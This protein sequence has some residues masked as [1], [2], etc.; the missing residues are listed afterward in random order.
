MLKKFLGTRYGFAA[1]LIV[2]GALLN[3]IMGAAFGAISGNFLKTSFYLFFI[4]IAPVVVAAALLVFTKINENWCYGFGCGLYY[5]TAFAA[6]I[7]PKINT[8]IVGFVIAALVC[9]IVYIK[10]QH[11]EEK[12]IV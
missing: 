9:C 2:I 5:G 4:F 12:D 10:K 8:I 3:L 1:W 11:K 7:I 6:S